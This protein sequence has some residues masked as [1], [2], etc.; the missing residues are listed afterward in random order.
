MKYFVVVVVILSLAVLPAIISD[1]ESST[2]LRLLCAILEFML[3]LMVS[4]KLSV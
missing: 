3:F 1:E 2:V 4:F